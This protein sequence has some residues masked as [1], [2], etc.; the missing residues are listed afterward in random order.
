MQCRRA[1]MRIGNCTHSGL[2]SEQQRLRQWPTVMQRPD[3]WH[4]L[5]LK[6]VFIL[7]F[8]H[9]LKVWLAFLN[10]QRE[11]LHPRRHFCVWKRW[12]QRDTVDVGTGYRLPRRKVY[13]L[14]HAVV[15]NFSS[16]SGASH[17]MRLQGAE[18]DCCRMTR[19]EKYL[20]L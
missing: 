19:I 3:W 10:H 2:L 18:S 20:E 6:P 14:V 7:A 4:R 12:H 1:V 9:Q 16:C 8:S 15:M 5:G 17:C 13:G 11:H